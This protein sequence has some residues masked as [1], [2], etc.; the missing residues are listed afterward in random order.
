MGS[1]FSAVLALLMAMGAG[2]A[3]A[4]API[5]IVAVG[6]SNTLGWGVSPQDAY[7]ARLQEMLRQRGYPAQVTNAGVILDTT[8]GMLQRID[9][10]VP[11]GTN[12]VI[13][14]PGGNDLRFFG[15]KEQRSA[16]IS[17]MVKRLRA[18]KIGVIV[19]DPV[20][21]PH[22]FQWDGIHLS[23]KCHAMFAAD[24]LPRVL[25]ALVGKQSR[26]NAAE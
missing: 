3:A 19:Y 5:H 14:Q 13:L 2:V 16:N 7:P 24:L 8:A 20:I 1:R 11:E 6:A 22:C 25:S 4:P 17:A 23:A 15:T 18:R 26:A 9:A 10:S 21:P 12:I